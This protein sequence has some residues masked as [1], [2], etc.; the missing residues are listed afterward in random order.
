MRKRRWF[1]GLSL[2]T[3]ITACKVSTPTNQVP[4]TVTLT[5][6]VA[7]SLQDATEA[8]KLLYEQQSPEINIVYNLGSSGSLQYQI[9]QGAPVDI[10]ISAAPKQMNVLEKK[11]LLL[12]NTWKNLLKNQ[13]VLIT[14]KADNNIAS[15]QDLT[16]NNVQKIAIGN[17][18]SVPAGQYAKEVL[19]SFNLSDK[20]T[21][22]FVFAK[23]VR[24][25]LF[26]V[27]TG[28]VDGGLIYATDAKI[29]ERVKVVA[30]APEN[31]HSPIIY[32]VAVIRN[33]QHPEEAK[34]FIHFLLS[35]TAQEVFKQYGF[36]KSKL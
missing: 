31:S 13:I 35:K 16:K 18:E 11:G 22:K 34:A 19:E 17:P 8:I 12:E 21:S 23:D 15:F 9:E 25:V 10:F 26:Y 27:E 32:P 2:A 3:L 7:A 30:T 33:S 6:S 36:T 1:I 4:P 14:P 28:N 24:Q 29:S 20:L 5:V